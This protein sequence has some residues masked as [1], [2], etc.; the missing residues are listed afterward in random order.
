M[1]ENLRK[2]QVFSSL[3]LEK[4]FSSQREE[5]YLKN[6]R[7]FVEAHSRR[8]DRI[9]GFDDSKTMLKRRVWVCTSWEND[10]KAFIFTRSSLTHQKCSG[11]ITSVVNPFAWILRRTSSSIISLPRPFSSPKNVH[12][13]CTLAKSFAETLFKIKDTQSLVNCEAK[14]GQL[15]SISCWRSK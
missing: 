9:P 7:A 4:I 13:L 10:F 15:R 2:L 3:S 5:F 8:S 1:D 12:E 11:I 6:V 14:R